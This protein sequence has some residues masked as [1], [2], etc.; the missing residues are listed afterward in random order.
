MPGKNDAIGRGIAGRD[1]GELAGSR[2]RLWI[3]NFA[4]R[5]GWAII[6]T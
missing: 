2:D 1:R 5:R 3:A 4:V 6:G